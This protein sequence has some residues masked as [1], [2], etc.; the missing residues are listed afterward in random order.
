MS[1]NLGELIVGGNGHFHCTL[2][3]G[4]LRIIS[5]PPEVIP[6]A[7]WWII[8]QYIVNPTSSG[9]H[10]F[11]SL[12]LDDDG[13]SLICSTDDLSHLNCL[14]ISLLTVSSQNWRAFVIHVVG[15]VTQYPGAVHHLGSLLSDKGI[16]IFHISTFDKEIFLIRE[17][18]VTETC[19]ILRQAS[20]SDHFPA[21]QEGSQDFSSTSSHDTVSEPPD[22]E[23]ILPSMSS[24]SLGVLPGSVMIAKLRDDTEFSKCGDILLRL[25]LYDQRYSWLERRLVT[26]VL[27]ST[28]SSPPED[29]EP[30]DPMKIHKPTIL[31]GLWRSG[32]ELTFLLDENDVYRFPEESLVISPQRWRVVKLCGRALDQHETGIV[33]AMSRIDSD[34]PTLNIS[35]SCTNYTLVPDDRLQQTLETLSVKLSCDIQEYNI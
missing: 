16:S 34:V 3:E 2:H 1:E 33:T 21:R 31:W 7:A 5:I 22:S 19:D 28:T 23:P 27:P 24:F 13:L 30:H 17:Q 10:S 35:T 14:N 9:N 25:L 32:E 29:R 20:V 15:S 18:D 4:F 11:N 8:R 6:S 12:L 26:E